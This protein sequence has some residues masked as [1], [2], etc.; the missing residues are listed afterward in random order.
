MQCT[1][2]HYRRLYRPLTGKEIWMPYPCGK[3]VACLHNQQDSWAIRLNEEAKHTERHE[4]IYDTLTF[5][6]VNLPL[7]RLESSEDSGQVLSSYPSEVADLL[8]RYSKVYLAN[9]GESA[10]AVP[11]VTRDIIRD[12][13]R[14][15]RELFVFHHGY[16]PDWKYVVFMEYGPKTSRPHFHLMFF[17]ITLSDYVK[18]LKKPWRRQYGFTKTHLVS[19]ENRKGRD[20]VSRYVSKYCSKGVF[21]SPL[22]RY[23][24]A[25]KCFRCI[26]HGIGKSYI[27]GSSF[28]FAR[29]GAVEVL[30]GIEASHTFD[31]ERGVYSGYDYSRCSVFFKS[32]GSSLFGLPSEKDLK[33]LQVYVDESSF[34]H[35]LPR[36]YKRILLGSDKPNYYACKVQD[37]LLAR[38]EQYYQGKLF[39]FALQLGVRNAQKEAPLLGLPKKQFDALDRQYFIVSCQK[40]RTEAYGRFIKLK[41]HY[42]RPLR[43][44]AYAY[45]S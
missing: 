45:V 6:D 28:D 31:S 42:L 23:G 15:G 29:T 14:R 35:S 10:L 26:S 32:F 16:R 20:C 2:L 12:W 19:N 9:T 13:I 44:K 1:D 18:Y 21:E 34:S 40:A 37:L 41:N 22:V 33:R 3:C 27:L 30:K 11:Y 7:A 38:T 4:F 25:P 43:N 17:N 8:G 36:Y 39:E 5:S 24:L